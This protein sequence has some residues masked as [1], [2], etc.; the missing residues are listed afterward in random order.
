MLDIDRF[1]PFNDTYG[2]IAGDQVLRTLAGELRN[3]IRPGMRRFGPSLPES[4]AGRRPTMTLRTRAIATKAS[5]EG[6]YKAAL[7]R[8]LRAA[9]GSAGSTTIGRLARSMGIETLEL[10]RIHDRVVSD[11]KPSPGST[12]RQESFFT[13]AVLPIEEEH[14]GSSE[15]LVSCARLAARLGRR[16]G[17]LASARTRLLHEVARKK[18]LQDELK[19][20]VRKQGDSNE[21]ASFMEARL[22]RLAHRLLT[23]HEE[24][25]RRLSRDLHD[26]IGQELIQ[27][28]V[29]LADPK[30]RVRL[31]DLGGGIFAS[32]SAEFGKFIADEIFGETFKAFLRRHKKIFVQMIAFF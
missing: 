29:G 21:H 16:T 7:G 26:A 30:I 9:K 23:A 32:T 10:A 11:L 20:S 19:R 24:E 6:S 15:A 3:G 12:S 31:A 5:F 8:H 14:C 1:K 13:G 25:R 2:H 4:L 28:N 18:S 22:R 27:I 17:E